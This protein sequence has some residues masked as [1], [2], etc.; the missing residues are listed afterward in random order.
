MFKDNFITICRAH[1]LAL[2]TEKSYWQ[3]AR[4]FI[5]WTG[6]KSAKEL[7]ADATEKFREYLSAMANQNP[8]QKFPFVNAIYPRKDKWA[9][10]RGLHAPAA[11]I[12]AIRMTLDT[13]IDEAQKKA[14]RLARDRAHRARAKLLEARLEEIESLP[15][16]VAAKD[17]A[18][19][20]LDAAT[21]QSAQHALIVLRDEDKAAAR[22][23]VRVLVDSISV[24]ST[25]RD[26]IFLALVLKMF[27]P[28]CL[29]VG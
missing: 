28:I 7:E 9:D 22:G 5:L 18:V 1:G 19:H 13:P 2:K 11:A 17:A 16:V 15:E 4:K 24:A 27:F 26:L 21:R 25:A 29:E 23:L 3:S 12:E 10:A 6:A 20:A 8:D 14:D